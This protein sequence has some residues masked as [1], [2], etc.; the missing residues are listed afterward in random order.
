MK[1]FYAFN[2][3]K[4]A[5]ISGRQIEVVESDV[6]L[7][8]HMA[9]SMYEEIEANNL[10]K[11][12]TT[13]ILP[14]GPVFQY[15]RFIILLKRKP[16]DLSRLHIFFMDEYL[17]KSGAPVSTDSPLSFRGFIKRELT[18]PMPKEMGLDKNQIYFPDPEHPESYD[19]R[20]EELGGITFCHAG[21]GISGHLA[22]NE[23][24]PGTE[25]TTDAFAILPTRVVNLTRETITINSNTAL[26]GAFEEIP[27]QAV[28]V[29]MKQILSAQKLQIYFNR[30]WQ[31][32]VCRKALLM[33]PTPEFPVTLAGNHPNVTYI[34]TQQVA[35][36]M[37]FSLK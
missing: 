30:P 22:F 9:L 3:D 25:I 28:T 21:V 2:T 8:Y 37:E 34:M 7:Y 5:E 24:V 15:R 35:E 36:P 33:D 20:I 32:A 31:G 6:D 27:K 1:D 13:C 19:N 26:R 17:N 23:P 4:L 12:P 18:N 29:G 11:K 10:L 16:L 14:V